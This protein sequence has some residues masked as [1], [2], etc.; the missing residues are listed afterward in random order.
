MWGGVWGGGN[1]LGIIFFNYTINE[2]R[3]IIFFHLGNTTK[4]E[5]GKRYTVHGANSAGFRTH[6]RTHAH[7]LLLGYR[8]YII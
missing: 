3:V 5:C 8:E 2:K 6:A 7:T 1:K 4:L